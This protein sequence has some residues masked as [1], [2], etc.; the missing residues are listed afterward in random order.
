MKFFFVIGIILIVLGFFGLRF[1]LFPQ[2]P[3]H[4]AMG[5]LSTGDSVLLLM[6]VLG[7]LCIVIAGIWWSLS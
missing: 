7:V 5:R 1:D 6:L 3:Y 4:R 2:S